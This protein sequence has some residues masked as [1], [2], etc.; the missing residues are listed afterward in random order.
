MSRLLTLSTFLLLALPCGLPAAKPKP[1]AED[2]P[3]WRGPNR[4]GVSKD[5]GLLSRWPKAGPPL[6]WQVKGMGSGYS[7]VAVSGNQVFTLGNRGGFNTLIAV[8]R[9]KGKELWAVKIRQGGGDPQSTPTVD[10][11]RVYGLTR[12]GDLFCVDAA[13][14]KLVWKKSMQND[15]GGHMMSG[16]GYSESPLVDSDKLVCTPGGKNATLIALDKKTGNVIWK[17]AVP[18][19]DGAGYASIVVATVGGVRQYIQLLGGG[20]VGVAAK[21]GKFLWRY[22]KIA[23]GT[24]NIPTPI[25]KDNL[26]FCSTGY[27]RGS[28]LLKLVPK[29]KGTKVEEVYFLPGNKLQNH[30]GGLVLVGNYIYGGHGHEQ[31][32]PVCVE[33]KTGKIV[34]GHG[35]GALGDNAGKKVQWNGRGP[36]SGSAAVVYADGNMYF[37][38]QNGLMALIGASPSGYQ[39]KGTFKIP[40]HGGAPSWSHP[41]VAGGKLYLREQDWLMCFDLRKK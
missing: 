24:A 16:W 38:Y 37:R 22:N 9:A 40:H 11:D 35:K 36:G 27:G 41:V 29:G 14:K 5:K 25:V 18:G 32:F 15:F 28:A 13:K 39:V 2:W 1:K 20:I 4:D 34:W 31:G 12:D 33:L 3:Q 10:G 26:V 19:G 21:D 17:A 23:N 7:S 30:H 8:D 6:A